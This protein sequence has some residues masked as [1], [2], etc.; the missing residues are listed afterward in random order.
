MLAEFYK[1]QNARKPKS[2]HATYLLT[3]TPRN[4]EQSN[5]SKIRKGD[6]TDM[7]SSPFMSSMPDQEENEDSDYDSSP[8]DE[9][10]P[11]PRGVKETQVLLVRE[12]EFEGTLCQGSL[13]TL[14]DC[15]TRDTCRTG[16]RRICPFLQSRTR[17]TRGMLSFDSQ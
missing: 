12:E 14:T 16:R 10:T 3:G 6:D 11:A 8:D 17:V 1:T 2:V 4:S 9:N 13:W 7:R 15:Y 5:G